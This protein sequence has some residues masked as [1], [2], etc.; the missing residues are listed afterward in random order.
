M[1]YQN[2]QHLVLH[3][4]GS[5]PRAFVAENRHHRYCRGVM[6]RLLTGYAASFNGRHPRHG[7]LFSIFFH[8]YWSVSHFFENHVEFIHLLVRNIL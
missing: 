7:H 5:T 3:V 6:R 8:L 1:F 2:P 4:F